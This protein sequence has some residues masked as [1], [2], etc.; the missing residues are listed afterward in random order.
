MYISPNNTGSSGLEV[1]I[2]KGATTTF[3]FSNDP[4]E[5]RAKDASTPEISAELGRVEGRLRALEYGLGRLR[6][7]VMSRS[8]HEQDAQ[9]E[10]AE[11]E[12]VRDGGDE[13]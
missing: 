5:L 10:I 1:S 13:Q 6:M 9:T 8:T 3:R 2:S 11:E 4:D 12:Q 7:D